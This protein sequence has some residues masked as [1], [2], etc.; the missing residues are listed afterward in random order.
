MRNDKQG[1]F[2]PVLL[3]ALSVVGWSGFQ[4]T[5][6]LIERNSLYEA[7]SAQETQMVQSATL[8]QKLQSLAGRVAKLAKGGNA[9][10]T[11]IVE[12]LRK[13]GITLSDQPAGGAPQD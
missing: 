6:L 11:L 7:I 10:A 3:L 12:E 5:Q 13:R 8:R 2:L 9:N 4:A 1:P